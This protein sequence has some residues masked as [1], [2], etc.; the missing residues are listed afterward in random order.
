MKS[1][2][3]GVVGSIVVALIHGNVFQ[4]IK[5]KAL[6]RQELSKTIAELARAFE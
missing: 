2:L 3:T 1:E 5:D 4:D 6:L